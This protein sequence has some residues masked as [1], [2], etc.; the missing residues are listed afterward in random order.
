MNDNP[1]AVKSFIGLYNEDNIKAGTPLV[2][3]K[4]VLLHLNLS[5]KDIRGQCYD[6]ASNMMGCKSGVPSQ[7]QKDATKAISSHCY[8]HSLQLAVSDVM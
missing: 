1:E 7:I 3:M 2:A 5:L 4:D 8:G 6:G